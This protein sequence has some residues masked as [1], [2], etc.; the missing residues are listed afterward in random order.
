MIQVNK[1]IKQVSIVVLLLLCVFIYKKYLSEISVEDLRIYIEGWGVFAPIAYILAFTILPIAFFPVPILAVVAGVVFGM[2]KGTI[3]TLI[4]AWMNSAVMF[5]MAKVLAREMI[6]NFLKDKLS[7]SMW[8]AFIE[9]DDKKAFFI[10]FVLRLI[11]AAPY[12]VINYGAGLSG[13]SFKSYIIATVI[14][15][16][17]GTVVFI[18]IGDKALDMSDPNFIIAIGLLVLLTV[19]SLILAKK[20]SPTKEDK[21]SKKI[22]NK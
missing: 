13:I 4:G 10:I 1:R 18:N 19:V 14:G 16:F 20:I 8:Q 6:L 17:P 2:F 21:E 11:P 9:A 7:P 12:N 5:I 15:I 3:Y 22:E